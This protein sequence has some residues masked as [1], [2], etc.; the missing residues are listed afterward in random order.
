MPIVAPNIWHHHD[1]KIGALWALSVLVPI[2]LIYS[3]ETALYTVIHTYLLEYIPF[4][5]LVGSLYTIAGGIR[6]Q[7]AHPPAPWFNTTL[8]LIGTLIASIVGTA[9]AAMLL[10]RPLLNINQNRKFR[11]HVVIFFIILVCNIGGCLTALGDPPLFLGF[12]N[13]VSFFWTATHLYGPF[14]IVAIPCLVIFFLLDTYYHRKEDDDAVVAHQDKTKFVGKVNL[15]FLAGVMGTVIL[16]GIWK[17][18]ITFEIFH[19][20]IEI[21]NLL[22]DFILLALAAASLKY[23]KRENRQYNLFTWGPVLEVAKLFAAIFITAAPVIAILGIGEAGALAPLV[24]LVSHN[25]VQNNDVYFWLTGL[26]SAFLDNAPTYLI[27][28]HLAGGNADYLMHQIPTTL[29]AI[30]AGAV[31]MG[32]LSYIGNAPNFMVKSIAEINGIRMPGF[33]GY[34]GWSCTILLPLFV[35]LSY[36]YF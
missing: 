4:I 10:I 8:M 6:I 30:S 28:F 9:G 31:F 5:I 29:A 12:L 17:P 35:I 22:R 19:N 27:F 34:M 16:S 32:A 1:G 25:G 23:S 7:L 13:G 3:F 24:K 2:V 36:F 14:L 18:G 21:Q 20:E 11:H 33:F 15:I 26:L